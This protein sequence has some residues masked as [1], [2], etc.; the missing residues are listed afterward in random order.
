[1]RVLPATLRYDVSAEQ[2][3]LDVLNHSLTHTASALIHKAASS[4][5][6]LSSIL[7]INCFSQLEHKSQYQRSFTKQNLE[8]GI[9][10]KYF[11]ALI[12]EIT[13]VARLNLLSAA[14]N[15]RFW[16]V[17]N[18]LEVRPCNGVKTIKTASCTSKKEKVKTGIFS[19]KGRGQTYTSNCRNP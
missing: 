12:Q 4:F 7:L 10:A 19:A 15:N 14:T 6:L 1:M 17:K 5:S 13:S 16:K 3:S 18:H 8:K 2:L 9:Y 11:T